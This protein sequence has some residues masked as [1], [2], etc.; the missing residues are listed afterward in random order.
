MDFVRDHATRARGTVRFWRDDEGW[1][2]IDSPETPGGCWAHFSDVRMDGYRTL[3]EGQEVDFSF[4]PAVQD[5][6]T[7]RAVEVGVDAP[8]G[9]PT[10]AE[11][12]G[13]AYRSQLRLED[14]AH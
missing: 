11:P 3:S 9:G 4:E 10:T 14:D 8:W 1:G 7:W 5:G 6:F 2:V 12:P 13:D